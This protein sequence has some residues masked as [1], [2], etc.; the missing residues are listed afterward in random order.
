M[1]SL[2]V[3]A[4]NEER[5]LPRLL[6]SVAAA[7]EASGV[8]PG[9]FE[10][11]IADNGSTDRTAAIAAA[12]GCRVVPSAPRSIGATRNAGARAARGDVL[13]FVDADSR[14][15]P[16]TFAE[17]VRQLGS[18]RVVGG[19]T[20]VTMDRWSA[21]IVAT[22][23]VFVPLVWLTGFDTGVVFCRRADFETVG[24][25][26]ERIRFGEDVAF[27]L[28]LWRLGRR[29]RR[30]LVRA[31]RAKAVASA[32]KFDEHGD[33]HYFGL[34]ARGIGRLVGLGDLDAVAERYWYQ[35]G[36]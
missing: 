22:W 27:L 29:T 11:I 14:I 4:Y 30:H 3:P 17:I 19:T 16:R 10:T 34:F 15:H 28:A 35:P 2:V 25:Y 33:W 6:D 20:G 26:D 21:G 36:R 1:I 24:G 7:A 5:Y 12:R 18:A 23:A 32:R 13:A 31:R 8:G 9:D